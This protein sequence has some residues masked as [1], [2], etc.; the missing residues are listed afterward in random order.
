MDQLPTLPN[1]ITLLTHVLKVDAIEHVSTKQHPQVLNAQ[2]LIDDTNHHALEVFHV[3][4]TNVDFVDVREVDVKLDETS[5]AFGRP[6]CNHCEYMI[7][8][9]FSRRPWGFCC[10]N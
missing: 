3:L 8:V 9:I 10:K 4:D 2:A 6:F 5:I 1:L 7:L